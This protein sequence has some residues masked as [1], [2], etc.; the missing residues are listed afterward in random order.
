MKKCIIIFCLIL[1][2]G[3]Y[4]TMS[5]QNVNVTV[6]ISQQPAWGPTGYDYAGY[7][8][9]PAAAR[10][11]RMYAIGSKRLD[12]CLT[13]SRL[14]SLYFAIGRGHS[15]GR[16]GPDLIGRID[17][18]VFYVQRIRAF[19]GIGILDFRIFPRRARRCQ[20]PFDPSLYNR[21]AVFRLYIDVD[22]NG[23]CDS[24]DRKNLYC[25]RVCILQSAVYFRVFHTTGCKEKG[26]EEKYKYRCVVFHIKS[27]KRKYLLPHLNRNIRNQGS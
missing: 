3:L 2:G 10:P 7:Y 1:S 12:A 4:G 17:L 13:D 25:R 9:F 22:G 11:F 6:N 24:I 16:V 8:Y 21:R 14:Y 15:V 19:A 20:T 5:A 18:D 23:S 27:I 26:L